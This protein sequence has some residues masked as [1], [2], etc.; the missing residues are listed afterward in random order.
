MYARGMAV[1]MSKYAWEQPD[2]VNPVTGRAAFRDGSASELT[3]QIP[4]EC[5]ANL[6]VG[7]MVCLNADGTGAKAVGRRRPGR[8]ERVF[9]FEAALSL[10]ARG[11]GLRAAARQL[12]VSAPVLMR[13]YRRVA[14]ER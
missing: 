3:E 10:R 4:A 6:N 8:P 12:G 14:R 9:D 2:Y 1:G 5:S 13:F 7:E 11:V